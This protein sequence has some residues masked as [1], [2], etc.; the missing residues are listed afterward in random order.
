MIWRVDA[1]APRSIPWVFIARKVQHRPP[2]L[3]DL[4]YIG[5]CSLTI[6]SY[7]SRP[8]I[9]L[10]RDGRKKKKKEGHVPCTRVRTL[11]V[12]STGTWSHQVNRRDTLDTS[13][14][15]QKESYMMFSFKEMY[16]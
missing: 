8:I 5:F 15:N 14:C 1:I 3:A 7:D 9:A 6:Y 11:G 4:P 13:P 2:Q 16:N 10:F 12:P